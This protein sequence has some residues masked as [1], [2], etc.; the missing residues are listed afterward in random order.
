MFGSNVGG[1]GPGVGRRHSA[2][3]G[4]EQ[5]SSGALASCSDADAL[6]DANGTTGDGESGMG[7]LQAPATE[8]SEAEE[9]QQHEREPPSPEASPAGAEAAAAA[10][11]REAAQAAQAAAREATEKLEA[12]DMQIALLR[13]ATQAAEAKAS[14]AQRRLAS[15]QAA[16]RRS[17]DGGSSQPMDT[18]ARRLSLDPAEVGDADEE[19]LEELQVELGAGAVAQ[20]GPLMLAKRN[21]DEVVVE[22]RNIIKSGSSMSEVDR[23]RVQLQLARAK[24]VAAKATKRMEDAFAYLDETTY[25]ASRAIMHRLMAEAEEYNRAWLELA[26]VAAPSGNRTQ[27]D[28]LTQRVQDLVNSG[29]LSKDTEVEMPLEGKL[30]RG[31]VRRTI[32]GTQVELSLWT[33]VKG[34]QSEP[35]EEGF[36]TSKPRYIVAPRQMCYQKVMIEQSLSEEVREKFMAAALKGIGAATMPSVQSK[37]WLMMLYTDANRTLP[38]LQSLCRAVIEALPTDCQRA[39]NTQVTPLKSA[40]RATLKALEKYEGS[41]CRLTDLVRMTFECSTLSAAVAVL[42]EVDRSQ[43]W[44]L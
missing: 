41:F 33:T 34:T 18:I 5:S 12:A 6:G 43:D 13:K 29:P 4:V 24:E 11:L 30:T 31:K 32:K 42:D 16:A 21:A 14:A 38:L 8:P 26:N 44:T 15:S 22:L 40:S 37:E 17:S 7:D 27:L 20:L 19:L 10:A 39:V 3:G 23:S 36:D 35:Y 28:V 1:S 9:T 2:G 25:E